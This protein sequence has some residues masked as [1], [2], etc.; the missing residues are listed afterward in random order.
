[1]VEARVE[2]AGV[3]DRAGANEYAVGS[4][5]LVDIAYLISQQERSIDRS[6]YILTVVPGVA[7]RRGREARTYGRPRCRVVARI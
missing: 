2:R 5:R 1:M 6:L 3:E 4:K 7:L